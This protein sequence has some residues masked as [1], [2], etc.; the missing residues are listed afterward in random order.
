MSLAKTLARKF[1][2]LSARQAFKK[3]GPYLKD[4][5]TDTEI[6]VPKT[7]PTIHKYN[8]NVQTTIPT[9]LIEQS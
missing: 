6:I 1:K 9:K 2:L 8:V 7:L 5:T 4:A 3:F